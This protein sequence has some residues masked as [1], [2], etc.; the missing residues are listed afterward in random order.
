MGVG[1]GV[2]DGDGVGAAVADG[3][4]VAVAMVEAVGAGTAELGAAE[5][6]AAELGAAGPPPH[7]KTR[8]ASKPTNRRRI[9]PP[10]LFRRPN[11]DRLSFATQL[12]ANQPVRRSS[13]LRK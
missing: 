4:G 3:D 13:Q 1:A 12:W 10:T 6:G 2:V 8:L 9:A 11:P 5:L 7:A